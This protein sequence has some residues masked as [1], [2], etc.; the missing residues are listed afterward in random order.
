M[1]LAFIYAALT[2]GGS[3]VLAL[4]AGMALLGVGLGL[5]A[6]LGRLVERGRYSDNPIEPGL[7]G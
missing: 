7:P 1:G 2:A 5:V 6:R 4:L 3:W